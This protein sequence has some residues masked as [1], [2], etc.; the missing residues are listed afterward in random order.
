MILS[1]AGLLVG[2][3]FELPIEAYAQSE[4]NLTIQVLN[5]STGESSSSN[6]VANIGDSII[7]YG[8]I[9][10]APSPAYPSA[11]YCCD[12]C[13]SII[14]PNNQTQLGTPIGLGANGLTIWGPVKIPSGV[15]SFGIQLEHIP[16]NTLSNVVSVTVSTSPAPIRD[17]YQIVSE[18]L[19]AGQTSIHLPT[20]NYSVSK[21]I[22]ISRPNVEIYGDGQR[23][24]VLRLNDSLL[25]DVL[26]FERADFFHVHDL[27]LDGNRQNQIYT[28]PSTRYAGPVV[29]NGIDAWN[30]SNGLIENCY[31]H[32]CRVFGISLGLCTNCQVLN[33]YVQNSDA[34]GITISNKDGGEGCLVSGNVVDG[35]SDV[36]ITGWDAMNY[37]VQNNTVKNI[38]MNSSPFDQNSHVGIMAEGPGNGTGCK[39]CIYSGNIISNVLGAGMISAPASRQNDPKN[40]N[41]NI[42]FDDNKISDCQSGIELDHNVGFTATNNVIDGIFDDT[43]GVIIVRDDCINVIIES[44]LI[45]GLPLFMKRAV[46]QLYSQTGAFEN[47][48]IY[49]NGNQA[50]YVKYPTGWTSTP[51]TIS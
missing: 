37:T 44:N 12:H 8:I 45:E 48:T 30:C 47:N 18:G 50:L 24:T 32:D 3:F 13:I 28:P 34:N 22:V 15:P 4:A 5:E 49:A 9:T 26:S 1:G 31:I 11:N 33:N 7:V 2:R 29:I 43:V 38:I 36:G 14:N 40:Q 46:V 19:A 35:A 27:Q 6:I 42:L 41:Q 39:N 17:A 10:P 25:Q 16:S 23:A 21:R 51:N 20:G